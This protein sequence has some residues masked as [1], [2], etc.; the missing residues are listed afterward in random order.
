MQKVHVKHRKVNKSMD[1][2]LLILFL[3]LVAITEQMLSACSATMPY[4]AVPTFT[5]TNSLSPLSPTPSITIPATSTLGAGDRR[6]AD[7]LVISVSGFPTPQ[8]PLSSSVVQDGPFTFDLRFYR[9]PIFGKNPIAPSL[10]SDL[11]GIG[12]YVVW[13]YHG[14]ALP[15]PA[16]IYWGVDPDLS[17]LLQ[18]SEYQSN[19]I[20]EGDKNGWT[21]GLILPYDSQAGEQIEAVIKIVTT[22]KSYGAVSYFTLQAGE[23]GLE[24]AEVSLQVLST[25]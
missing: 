3:S 10:Y 19:G 15:P 16:T 6:A 21:G 4:T 8:E 25:Q 24:P 2:K 9:D 12:I 14:P 22:E 18:Q 7:P 1:K 11:E 20:K 5:Q 23:N 13:E 17:P